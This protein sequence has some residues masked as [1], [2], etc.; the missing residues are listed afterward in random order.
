[1]KT[2]NSIAQMKLEKRRIKKE[3]QEIEN[4]IKLNWKDLKAHLA[5]NN[6]AKESLKPFISNKTIE[7]LDNESV[8]KSTFTYAISLLASKFADKAEYNFKKLFKR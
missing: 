5:P 1:M 4:R 3:K 2:I 6:L 8:F 7:N